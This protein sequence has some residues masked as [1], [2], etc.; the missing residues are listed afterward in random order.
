MRGVEIDPER[1]RARVERRRAVGRRHRRPRPSTASP[2]LAGSSPDVGVVGYTLGGGLSWL[3]RK[4]G[5]AANSV[6]AIELVTA[7]GRVVLA[8]AEHDPD[9]FWALRGGGGNFGVV[10]AIEFELYPVDERLRRHAGVP[11]ERAAR[12]LHAWREWADTVPDEVTSLG[13]ILQVPPL[14]DVPEP[15][16]GRSSSWS[17]RRSSA[18]RRRRRAARAAA[19][20]RPGARHVRPDAAGRPARAPHGPAAARSPAMGDHRL[21]D[22]VPGE[23]IDALVAGR[24]LGLAAAVGRAAPPRRRA[25]AAGRATARSRRSTATTRCSPSAWRPHD[26]A[27]AAVGALDVVAARLPSGTPAGATSTSQ[28]APS[29]L[30]PRTRRRPTG[31]CGRSRRSST[32]TT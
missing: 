26:E 17:R 24:R 27:A 15:L 32:R 11:W 18:T 19:R 22:V 9:L 1:R 2:P 21:L 10:T 28:S 31:G 5:L 13:R 7:D 3:A 4:Y 23:A 29:T 25:R 16:R 12:D 14:P 8:D 20:A 30:A 6:T